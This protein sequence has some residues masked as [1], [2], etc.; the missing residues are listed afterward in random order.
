MLRFINICFGGDVL[1]NILFFLLPKKDVVF[2]NVNCSL[3]FAL[4]VMET[5]DYSSIPIVGDKGKYIGAVTQ[6]DL[7]WAFKN[8]PHIHF[9]NCSKYDLKDIT[10]H[11]KIESVR[12][13][14]PLEEIINMAKHQNF[15][16]V[17]DDNG[18]FIGIIRRQDV[19]DYLLSVLQEEDQYQIG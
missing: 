7:L 6:G 5:N 2:L 13:D 4:E 9:D 1:K 10:L 11:K 18:T 8:N 17:T 12:I 19:I 16:P 14:Q 3:K 15:I